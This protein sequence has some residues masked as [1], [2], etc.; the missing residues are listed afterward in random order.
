MATDWAL[1][2]DLM[3]AVIDSAED[4]EAS[5]YGERD[6]DRTVQVGAQAVS[7][8]DV[9]VSAQTIAEDLR[10]RIIRDRHDAGADAPYV[11]ETARMILR[12]AEACAELIGA[13]EAKPAE[14]QARHV[15]DWYRGHALPL[16]RRAM[17][18]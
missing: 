5:G 4:I 10:Y 14:A 16:V 13:A 1:I 15:I 18:S 6:Q 2:R 9:M 11:P 7:L 17:A 8:H 3:A 12:M